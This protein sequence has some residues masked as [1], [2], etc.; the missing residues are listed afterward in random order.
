LLTHEPCKITGAV[1]GLVALARAVQAQPALREMFATRNAGD[2]L[3][4]L[5]A[6]EGGSA[7]RRE[8]D[9]LLDPE[10]QGLRSGA[11]WG[12]EQNQVLPGWREQPEPVI[13]LVQK[14]A[15]LDL[16]ALAT[17]HTEAI[18]RRDRR[19]AEIRA[20]I[21][22]ETQRERFDFWL[23]AGRRAV[24]AQEDHNYHIDSATN[25]LLHRA[26]SAC[27]R[28]LAAA[29]V[30]DDPADVWWLREHQV[31]AALQGL[32][33]PA[34]ERPEH[35]RRLVAAQK[36][37]HEWQ[38][39]LRPPPTLGAPRPERRPTPGPPASEHAAPEEPEPSILLV[40]G[41]PGA[42]GTRSGRVRL[43]DH[44]QVVPD[45]RPG[46]VLV[47][48]SAGALWGPAAPTV[49]GVVLEVGGPFQ[50][51]MVVC[52]EYGVP[53]IV[54]A[55]GARERLRDGQAVIVDAGRGWVLA[56]GTA[57]EEDIAMREDILNTRK[58]VV[59]DRYETCVRC[60]Q[61]VPRAQIVIPHVS[62]EGPTALPEDAPIRPHEATRE[63]PPLPLCPDCVRDIAAGEPLELP[64]AADQPDQR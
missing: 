63:A 64:E 11:S 3:A 44:R 42:A 19:A 35:W 33:P 14:Y 52:R 48:H 34:H 60:G 37:L 55:K 43:V 10:Q 41:Q 24:Q 16:D 57:A 53:G 5:D 36:A 21:A 59:G 58:T 49:A 27:G 1:E 39:S 56:A 61:P 2:V 6:V 51:I 62:G 29:G 4:A 17:S 23:A 54:N 26:I 40:K 20:A 12:V 30:L 9:A 28:R 38:R 25:A 22:D 18:A 50:H 47:A 45:V 13:R 46:D 7:F 8:L 15:A 32:L 31:T